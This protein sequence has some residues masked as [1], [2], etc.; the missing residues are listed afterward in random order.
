VSQYTRALS[1][2]KVGVERSQQLA[3]CACF[4]EKLQQIEIADA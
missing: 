2:R 3:R 4:S 1:R